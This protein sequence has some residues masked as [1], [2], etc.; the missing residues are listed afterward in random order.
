M[1]P[2]RKVLSRKGK[3][4]LAKGIGRKLGPKATRKLVLHVF[5]DQF[6]R[7]KEESKKKRLRAE[8]P[9]IFLQ[10]LSCFPEDMEREKG[11]G[12]DAGVSI[13]HGV[14]PT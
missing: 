5:P 10:F 7:N 12:H 13:R 11:Q 1:A 3:R 14:R 2:G 6:P 9:Q 4:D 8:A